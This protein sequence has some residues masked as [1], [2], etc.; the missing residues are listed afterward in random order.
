[1]DNYNPQKKIIIKRRF[2]DKK[3][4]KKTTLLILIFVLL[5]VTAISGCMSTQSSTNPS[6]DI[7]LQQQNP[8]SSYGSESEVT[9]WISSKSKKSY[10]NIT[11]LVT[12][13]DSAGG[14][15]AQKQV[16]IDY[17]DLANFQHTGFT[18]KL[19]ST[20][21]DHIT[22]SVLNATVD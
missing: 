15:V 5:S 4:N 1:M 6:T 18:V 13:L 11:L 14:A 8:P 12:G 16:H 2:G 21:V 22:I 7:Y 10:S 20:K 19:P 3:L 9:A 17:M